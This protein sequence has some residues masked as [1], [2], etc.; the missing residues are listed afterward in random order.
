MNLMGHEFMK[1]GA[2]VLADRREHDGVF[3]PKVV[4]KVGESVTH[5]LV[6]ASKQTMWMVHIKDEAISILEQ[7]CKRCARH[8]WPLVWTTP[9]RVFQV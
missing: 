8:Q 6:V 4:K 2:D 3:G 9:I 7:C 1:T 5:L